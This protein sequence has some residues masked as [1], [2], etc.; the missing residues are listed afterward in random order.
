MLR[1][2]AEGNDPLPY[3]AP[4]TTIDGAFGHESTWCYGGVESSR[5]VRGLRS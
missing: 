4:E 3:K 5:A 2:L 1:K